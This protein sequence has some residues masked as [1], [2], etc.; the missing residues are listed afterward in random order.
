MNALHCT[1]R[2]PL[3]G[4]VTCI[5]DELHMWVVHEREREREG[6]IRTATTCTVIF[7][8]CVHML[9]IWLVG[10]MYTNKHGH[11]CVCTCPRETLLM[12]LYISRLS[13]ITDFRIF[14]LVNVKNKLFIWNL[15]LL[16][17]KFSFYSSFAIRARYFIFFH[18]WNV[19]F[20]LHNILAEE[21]KS[22]YSTQLADLV[23][24]VVC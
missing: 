22:F 10:C 23:I 19:G 16:M 13:F 1:K 20:P 6:F 14:Y 7:T 15:M 12:S 11:R 21:T 24:A 8:F 4:F 17:P 18:P 9:W 3:C 2:F 5:C